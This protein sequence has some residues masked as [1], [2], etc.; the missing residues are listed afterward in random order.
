MELKA[1]RRH[2]LDACAAVQ[3][4]E[5]GSNVREEASAIL[6]QINALPHRRGLALLSLLTLLEACVKGNEG[7]WLLSDLGCVMSQ[8]RSA[9]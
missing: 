2:G 8:N 1:A 3:D 5:A 4:Q 7:S 6:W 9:K